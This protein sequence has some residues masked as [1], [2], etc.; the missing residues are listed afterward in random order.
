MHEFFHLVEHPVHEAARRASPLDSALNEGVTDLLTQDTYNATVGRVRRDPAVI[1]AVEGRAPA[2][3]AAVPERYLPRRYT[4]AYPAEVADV[5]G[6]LGSV[7]LDGFKAAYLT[8]HVEYL[9]L[10]PSGAERTPVAAGTGR[11]I[12]LSSAAVHSL[13]DLVRRT[14]VP[15]RAIT[16][17][18]PGVRWSPMPARANVPG[19]R[20]H[21]V[22]ASA[23]LSETRDQ[24]AAQHDVSVADLNANNTHLP[25]WP[26][27]PAGR[28]VLVPPPGFRP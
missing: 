5:R 26:L 2:S 14:R 15:R 4:I 23:G 18:N 9:G 27:L 1:A 24:I 8:G 16:A 10:L 25:G 19:W 12:D 6:A 17:A 7:N 11:G 22:V 21:L 3:G 28:R 13:A 20:E